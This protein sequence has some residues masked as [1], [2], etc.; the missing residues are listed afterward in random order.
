MRCSGTGTSLDD[1]VF[2]GQDVFAIF[3]SLAV[4]ALGK[5]SGSVAG[6]NL[7]TAPPG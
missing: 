4:Y 3:R 6:L 1:L 7:G 5:R 2:T